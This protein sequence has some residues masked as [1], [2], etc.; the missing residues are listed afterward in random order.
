MRIFQGATPFKL[1]RF[2]PPSA[3]ATPAAS[4][5]ARGIVICIF[6]DRYL[7]AKA[8]EIHERALRIVY[9]DTYADYEASL[10]RGSAMSVHQRNLQYLITEIYKTKNRLNPSFMR[11]LFKP[12]DLQYDLRNKNTADIPEVS[13]TSYGI[14]T[15]QCISQKLWLMLPPSVRESHH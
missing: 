7:N 8:D 3:Q 6:H 1:W 11:E 5:Q 15:W 13:T 14:E 9:K 2:Y 12:R 4:S 10:K